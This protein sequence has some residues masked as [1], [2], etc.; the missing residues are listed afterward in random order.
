MKPKC[1]PYNQK[2][3]E[4]Q[5]QLLHSII[6]FVSENSGPPMTQFL[7][8]AGNNSNL[9]RIKISL[10]KHVENTSLALYCH[11]TSNA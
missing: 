2:R 7:R 10:E 4:N 11:P 8:I 5:R 6:V 1:L 9:N 3:P